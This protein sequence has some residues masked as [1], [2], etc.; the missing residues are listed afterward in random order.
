[1]I[2]VDSGAA[3]TVGPPS[4]AKHIPVSQTWASLG[5]FYYTAANRNPLPNTGEKRI[6]GVTQEGESVGLTMQV[7]DVTKVL[8]S[9]EQ[10]CKANNRVVIDDQ[11]VMYILNNTTGRRTSLVE[12][13]GYTSCPC[14]S[15]HL[16]EQWDWCPRVRQQRK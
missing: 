12:S 15:I 2:T 7:A 13:G 8:G 9:V 3:D 11:A 1:M 16:T 4:I 6:N 10:L 5:G 14:G